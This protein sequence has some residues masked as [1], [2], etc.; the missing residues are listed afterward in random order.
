MRKIIFLL[1]LV[2]SITFGIELKNIDETLKS[3]FK[4]ALNIMSDNSIDK[5]QKPLKIFEIFDG[6]FDYSLMARLSLSKLYKSLDKA[7]QDEFTN[8]FISN[9]KLSFSQK[10]GYYSDQ[11]I[12]F[13]K[14]EL[15]NK[16]RYNAYA[17]IKS[18]NEDYSLVLKFHPA[19]GQDYLIYDIDILGV[20]IIQSY[21]SQFSDLSQNADFSEI[22]KR[23]QSVN[24]DNNSTLD[25]KNI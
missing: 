5:E 11:E 8:L 10:L 1:F 22:I 23:L 16:N 9:L 25:E 20:S 18:K 13:V 19:N 3:D 4:K 15:T 7:K 17:V 6:Y 2:C 21:R 12:E 14:G 24:L